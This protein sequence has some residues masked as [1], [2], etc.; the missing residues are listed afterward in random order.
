MDIVIDIVKPVEYISFIKNH[1][2]RVK[3]LKHSCPKL[4]KRKRNIIMKNN[5][6]KIL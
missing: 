2:K 4:M 3:G 6:N 5:I 1:N